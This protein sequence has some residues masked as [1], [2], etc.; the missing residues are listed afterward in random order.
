MTRAITIVASAVLAFD[1]A[2]LV[3]FGL[4]TD[5]LVLVLVG[6]VFFVSSGLVVLY[7]RWYRRRV[8]DIAAARRALGDEAREMQRLLRDK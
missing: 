6:A 1:G 3:G 7:W 5:R 4:R 2:A 8:A